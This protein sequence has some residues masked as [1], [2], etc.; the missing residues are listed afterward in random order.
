L[1]DETDVTYVV[2]ISKNLSLWTTLGPQQKPW[3]VIDIPE[4]PAEIVRISLDPE[5]ADTT[6]FA[7]SNAPNESFQLPSPTG[8]RP[9]G[10]KIRST[11][12]ST[13]QKC[14]TDPVPDPFFLK[15]KSTRFTLA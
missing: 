12:P 4:S 3:E 9:S 13:I 2:E 6:R 14:Q 8:T 10:A 1:K 7:E 11:P 15:T 5:S